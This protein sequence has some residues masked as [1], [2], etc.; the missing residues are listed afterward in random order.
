MP[1]SAR[2]TGGP[3]TV[4][5]P[6]R[7][8][9]TIR[10]GVRLKPGDAIEIQFPNSWL[11]ID[12]PSFTRGV[13]TADPDG[14]HFMALRAAGARF[15]LEI[16]KRHLPF[17]GCEARHGR[18]LVARV[19]SGS[20]PAGGQVTCLYANT[21]AP[22]VAERETVWVKVRD[23]VLK[24]GLEIVTVAGPAVDLRLV[25]PSSA[26]PGQ[27]FEV[28]AVSLD[29][30][31][32]RSSS[33]YRGRTLELV[34]SGPVA[35]KLAFKGGARIPV[36]L[37]REGVFRF[38]MDG[39]LSNAVRVSK[40]ARGPYWGDIHVHTRV[41]QD[42][43]GADP[44]GYSRDVAG[45]DFAGVVDHTEGMGEDG[46]RQALRWSREAHRPG[47]FVIML[48]DERNPRE[49]TGHHNVYYRN[50]EAFLR[51]RLRPGCN[52]GQNPA[53]SRES[54]RA[55]LDDPGS[56]LVIPHHTG[57][58]WGNLRSGSIGSAVR[59]EAVA[60]DR[61]MRPVMEIYSHHGQSELYDPGHILAYEFNRMRNPERRSNASVDGPFYARDYWAAGRRLGVIGSSDEHTGWGGRRH[62]GAAAVFARELTREGVFDALCERRCYATT[63]ER[64]L[65]DFTVDGVEMGQE[66]RRARGAK[67]PVRLAVWGTAGLIRVDVLRHRFGTD[68]GF[69]LIHSSSPREGGTSSIAAGLTAVPKMV[70]DCQVELEEEFTGPVVYYARVVQ[71]PLE[72]PA[73]AWSSPV[74]LDE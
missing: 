25:V 64:I 34:G 4:G 35:R 1:P 22:C 58:G 20:V 41:S 52:P 51:C 30:F 8:R 62:G 48:G 19:A 61:G 47:R 46:Y 21:V 11:M 66:A 53:D 59:F 6:A 18:V 5:G 29:R 7:V 39:A 67:L 15:E 17:P 33:A 38:R 68:R 13:Q 42:G 60:D 70:T 74:W 10:P 14:A 56:C 37:D 57:M 3:F 32:N 9:L 44:Y 23:Q 43:L 40:E 45:L 63:G 73:M 50:E 55:V 16:L 12:G 71:E 69:A 65:L 31:E 24:R 49:W 28:L 36:R 26:R 27:R 2:I 54:M 72:W